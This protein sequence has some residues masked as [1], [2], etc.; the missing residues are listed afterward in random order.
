MM[1][2][3][4]GAL[5]GAKNTSAASPDGVGYKLIKMICHTRLGIEVL[6]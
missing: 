2:L 1:E 4:R 3:V 6:G 5:S